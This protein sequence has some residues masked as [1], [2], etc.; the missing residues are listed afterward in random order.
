MDFS[1][2][3]LNSG[4]EEKVPLEEEADDAV[5]KDGAAAA[6]GGDLR[7]D[8]FP[9]HGDGNVSNPMAEE[10]PVVEA[11]SSA[12][13]SESLVSEHAVSTSVE[14]PEVE[15]A[16]PDD[17]GDFLDDLLEDE[18]ELPTL[19][20]V[21]DDGDNPEDDDDEEEWGDQLA[22]LLEDD[23]EDEAFVQPVVSA[24]VV[25]KKPVA[26]APVV[27]A[28]TKDAVPGKGR[29]AA[30]RKARAGK[31]VRL[32]SKS[33]SCRTRKGSLEAEMGARG[34]L[35]YLVDADGVFV[36]VGKPKKGEADRFGKLVEAAEGNRGVKLPEDF[37]GSDGGVVTDAEVAGNVVY[38]WST[39]RETAVARGERQRK[40][41]LNQ[42]ELS[43]YRELGAKKSEVV[44][45]DFGREL[46]EPV[47]GRE[48]RTVKRVRDG[49]VSR[50]VGGHAG[51]A[52]GAG[53]AVTLRD[54]DMLIFLAK[55][56]YATAKQLSNLSGVTE[57]TSV[58]RLSALQR[59]GL[60]RSVRLWGATPVWTLTGA[61]MVLSGFDL[62]IQ[63]A[64]K[65]SYAS[66]AHQFVVNNTA[67]NL[68][69]GQA[70]VLHLGEF[71]L[72]NRVDSGGRLRWGEEVV[73][74]TEIQS[75]FSRMRL[76]TRAEVYRPLVLKSL[77][78]AF[79]EW[80]EAGKP[81]RSPEFM[82]G[83]EYM[84][85]IYPPKVL[86]Q[87]Y[88]AP[89]L[90]VRRPRNADGTP[91]SIAIEVELAS[92]DERK[93]ERVLRVYSAD[94]RIY[95]KVIWVCKSMQTAKALEKVAKDIG[96]FQQGRLD[97]V[98]ITTREG[99]FEGRDLWT[100]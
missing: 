17:F 79:R 95:K 44:A 78:K 61:G 66:I 56:K 82:F 98:P 11:D 63:Q 53:S 37:S 84:W 86:Q 25:A 41:R 90:V 5:Q 15:E 91:E 54:Q 12:V 32:H 4:K 42:D 2:I 49:L 19:P 62:P 73:S 55:F 10:L 30:R 100:I 28:T 77:E 31:R 7:F 50:G 45:G 47:S 99:I 74:E 48:A 80:E 36:P 75:S 9:L 3:K 94:N 87:N 59:K 65:I 81:S 6:S 69:G 16:L 52:A 60:V 1:K 26:A 71:P 57:R 43:F 22:D 76:L 18:D 40:E 96:L 23:D 88:H 34:G 38:P 51:Y 89:D 83:N 58:T 27:V 8:R 92:K 93:Y 14:M 13:A 68:M 46:R 85:M 21:A 72:Q 20:V 97:I 29:G 67:S 70:N 33:S 39:A 64:G 35:E 24:P